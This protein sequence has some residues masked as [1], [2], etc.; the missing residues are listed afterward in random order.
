MYAI[1]GRNEDN[2]SVRGYLCPTEEN[3]TVGAL[4]GRSE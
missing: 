2:K 3:F 4:T 1:G